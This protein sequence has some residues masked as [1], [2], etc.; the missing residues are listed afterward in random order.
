ML[1][2][3]PGA[4]DELVDPGGAIRGDSEVEAEL[5]GG[6]WWSPW[7]LPPAGR[8][9]NLPESGSKSTMTVT[10]TGAGCTI[11]TFCGRKLGHAAPVNDSDARAAGG[12]SGLPH[13]QRDRGTPWLSTSTA[14][15][16]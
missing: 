8:P 12:S 14:V 2:E 15:P 9:K 3:E 11:T 13:A 1:G 6:V 4:V 7:P 10:C 5:G 16:A